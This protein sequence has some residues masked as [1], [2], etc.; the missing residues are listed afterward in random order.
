MLRH[1]ILEGVLHRV[2]HRA[3]IAFTQK[4]SLRRLSGLGKGAGNS[5][6]GASTRVEAQGDILLALPHPHPS[7]SSNYGRRSCRSTQPTEA[8]HVC[9]RGAKWLPLCALLCG[10]LWAPRPAGDEAQLVR[11]S[12][13]GNKAAGPG[14]VDRASFLLGGSLDQQLQPTRQAMPNAS[15]SC[16]CT[17]LR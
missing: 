12:A 16:P 15:G 10:E 13:L 9:T 8:V 11:C 5:A 7:C 17:N 3:G 6:S 2:L 1:D 4:P 14:G